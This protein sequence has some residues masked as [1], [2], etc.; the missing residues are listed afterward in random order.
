MAGLE[1][2]S[3]VWSTTDALQKRSSK[4]E[5]KDVNDIAFRVVSGATGG[6]TPQKQEEGKTP[7]R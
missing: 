5:S 6:D 7:L 3:R 1:D 2:S 4:G